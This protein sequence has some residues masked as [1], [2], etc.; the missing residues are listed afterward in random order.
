LKDLVFTLYSKCRKLLQKN[1]N[2]NNTEYLISNDLYQPPYILS[3]TAI[4][5]PHFTFRRFS[6]KR[7]IK[8]RVNIMEPDRILHIAYTTI[9]DR[10]VAC[11]TDQIGEL[12][13]IVL[14]DDSKETLNSIA[15][16]DY[17]K[18]TKQQIRFIKVW[19]KAMKIILFGCNF[20]WRIAIIKIGHVLQ[21]EI[22][23]NI[24]VHLLYICYDINIKFNYL[25]LFFF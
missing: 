25:L 3:Q 11:M 9:D 14:V 20:Y 4:P 6:R 8:N 18:Y 13:D 22:N 12:F 2:I 16:Q 19:E 15:S 21:N 10:I 1:I 7:Q 24:Y 5:I 23:G 17:E